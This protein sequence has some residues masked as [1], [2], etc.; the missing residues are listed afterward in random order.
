[1]FDLLIHWKLSLAV[2][3][4]PFIMRT[5]AGNMQEY[6]EDVERHVKKNPPQGYDSPYR[7]WVE[8]SW[9]CLELL[10]LRLEQHHKNTLPEMACQRSGRCCAKQVPRVSVYEL[11]RMAQAMSRMPDDRKEAIL[12]RCRE[13]VTAKYTMPLFGEGVACPMLER[14]ERGVHACAVHRDRPVVCRSFGMT[15]P[16]SWDCPIWKVY[17]D[18]FPLMDREL[19]RPALKLFGYCRSV[20]AREMLGQEETLKQMMLVGPGL[21]A[22]LGEDP[23]QPSDPTVTAVLSHT[24]GFSDDLYFKDIPPPPQ[25]APQE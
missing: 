3:L 5:V 1:M 20:Y 25:E 8:A 21:L 2:E 18:R 4:T 6:L 22:L 23:P 24:V 15:T 9:A 13:S 16:L 19:A 14:D 17:G 11:E 10:L 12:Q 7:V